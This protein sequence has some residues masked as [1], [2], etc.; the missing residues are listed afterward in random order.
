MLVTRSEYAVLAGHTPQSVTRWIAE[1][2]L[3]PPAIV[4]EGRALRID[5]KIADQQLDQQLDIAKRGPVDVSDKELV[6]QLRAERVR[7]ARVVADKLERDFAAEA[8]DR[9]AVEDHKR[10]LWEVRTAFLAMIEATH[11]GVADRLKTKH[12][13]VDARLVRHALSQ[14]F[15]EEWR[16]YAASRADM[17]GSG[18]E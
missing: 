6:R 17:F 16:R 15:L 8:E 3:T 13:E 12:P 7:Q 1:G 4:G 14:G 2:K 9:I 11:R 18:P 10:A 5:V